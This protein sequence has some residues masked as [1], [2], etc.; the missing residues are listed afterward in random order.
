MIEL[1]PRLTLELVKIEE[2]IDEG[3]VLYHSYIT[4]TA[5]ELIKQRKEL[6][7][8]KWVDCVY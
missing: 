1:G 3:E 6:P 4:K 7:K 8:K 2:G 5:K